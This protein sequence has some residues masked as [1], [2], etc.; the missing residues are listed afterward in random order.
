MSIQK[1]ILQMK[2]WI[3]PGYLSQVMRA[4]ERRMEFDC[5]NQTLIQKECK[6]DMVFIGDS[7]IQMWEL[8][9]YFQEYPL[10]IINR[11]IGGDRTS[12]L[13]HRFRADA[14]QLKPKIVVIMAGINDSWDLE[15]DY[16]KQ[17]E[18][19]RLENILQ[20]ALTN[21]EKIVKISVEEQVSVVLCSILPTCM[22]WTNHERDRQ[23]YV[24]LYNQEL[25]KKAQKYG[26]VF[27]D[28]YPSFLNEDGYSLRRELSLEG[29]HPNVF[30][31]DIMA[32]ILKDTLR[33]FIK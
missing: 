22:E 4:D 20:E 15:F 21:M 17:E 5:K 10:R 2:P 18:G 27:V 7:I 31:Y 25:K 30:G 14:V 8:S 24:H 26:V 9:A 33:F 6:V 28:Y 19:K 11:G 1:N 16:W 3:K 32:E 23:K 13:L 29:L 12:S